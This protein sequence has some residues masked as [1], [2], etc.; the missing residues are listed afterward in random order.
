M[1]W[2]YNSK[3]NHFCHTKKPRGTILQEGE[4]PRDKHTHAEELKENEVEM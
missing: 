2:A 3:A 4:A 1:H